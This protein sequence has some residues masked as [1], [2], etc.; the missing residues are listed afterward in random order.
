MH[1]GV[2]TELLRNPGTV[3]RVEREIKSTRDESD[4]RK[5]GM[6]TRNPKKTGWISRAWD[7]V[8]T[9]WR[10]TLLAAVPGAIIGG[11]FM[12]MSVPAFQAECQDCTSYG[13]LRLISGI[14]ILLITPG[15]TYFMEKRLEYLDRPEY[16]GGPEGQQ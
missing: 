16:L 6:A 5:E 13:F 9:T 7:R 3:P 8:S 11:T 12:A 15:G 10:W 1:P 14:V 2:R 4:R